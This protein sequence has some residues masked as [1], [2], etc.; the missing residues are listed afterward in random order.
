MKKWKSI[1]MTMS[2]LLW[3]GAIGPEVFIDPQMGCFVTKEGETLTEEEA[4]ELYELL[5][6]QQEG[7]VQIVLRSKLWDWI[8]GE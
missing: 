8:F 1:L 2:A 7:Q 3:I 4:R 6:V 5:Y